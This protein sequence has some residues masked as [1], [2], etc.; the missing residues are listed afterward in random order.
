M[1]DALSVPFI[2]SWLYLSQLFFSRYEEDPTVDGVEKSGIELQMTQNPKQNPRVFQD[3]SE[4]FEVEKPPPKLN[5]KDIYYYVGIGKEGDQ[6][7][8]YTALNKRLLW[9]DKKIVKPGGRKAV[10]FVGH[11]ELTRIILY[12][13]FYLLH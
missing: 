7:T 4:V 13:Y 5:G 6:V 2:V 12:L 10:C 1:G 3:R 8:A 11:G 9:P